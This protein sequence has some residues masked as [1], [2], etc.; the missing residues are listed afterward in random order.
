LGAVSDLNALYDSRVTTGSTK[1]DFWASEY[2]APMFHESRMQREYSSEINVPVAARWRRESS[3]EI[4]A[5][6]MTPSSLECPSPSR[7]VLESADLAQANDML[8]RETLLHAHRGETPAH[9]CVLAITEAR[10]RGLEEEASRQR[11]RLDAPNPFGR[12]PAGGLHPYSSTSGY[13]GRLPAPPVLT[14]RFDRLPAYRP[15]SQGAGGRGPG[16]TQSSYI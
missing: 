5:R 16:F 9:S 15:A 8:A 6:A 14:Y 4:P 7:T 10:A 2:P 12:S 13:R 11:D 3:R 1:R